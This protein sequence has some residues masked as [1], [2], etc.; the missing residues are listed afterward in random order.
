MLPYSRVM[1][2]VQMCLWVMG[3]SEIGPL[4]VI[5][6]HEEVLDSTLIGV[7]GQMMYIDW[8]IDSD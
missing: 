8:T 4:I 3:S 6:G 2:T 7:G 1:E 5:G